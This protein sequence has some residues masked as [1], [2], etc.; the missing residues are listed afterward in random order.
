MKS[1]TS[2]AFA[3]LHR[4]M[5]VADRGLWPQ[6]V[7][8]LKSGATGFLNGENFLKLNKTLN[9]DLIKTG[10]QS[11]VLLVIGPA[12]QLA[13]SLASEHSLCKALA[14]SALPSRAPFSLGA[15]D[16]RTL[17]PAL[18]RLR[19]RRLVHQP[20]RGCLTI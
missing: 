11:A 14:P 19:G 9:L 12:N 4:K 8:Y 10:T 13:P 2:V 1:H 5:A 3:T 17:G 15:A 6:R 20:P 16:E 7:F 18:S